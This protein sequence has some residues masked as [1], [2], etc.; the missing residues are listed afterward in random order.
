[1][2]YPSTVLGVKHGEPVSVSGNC[3][4]LA[5]LNLALV[6]IRVRSESP[7]NGFVC[8]KTWQVQ[9]RHLGNLKPAVNDGGWHRAQLNGAS[10]MHDTIGANVL[11]LVWNEDLLPGCY[12]EGTFPGSTIAEAT[13]TLSLTYD[14]DSREKSMACVR[15]GR[16]VE[17]VMVADRKQTW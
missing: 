10:S 6:N 4:Y 13:L 8:H 12:K 15:V 5:L 16:R 17:A 14:N 9:D 2:G 7:N 11:R 3:W 1:M